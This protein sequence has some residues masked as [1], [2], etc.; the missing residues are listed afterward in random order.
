MLL[1]SRPMLLQT[2]ILSQTFEYFSI[3]TTFPTDEHE[4]GVNAPNEE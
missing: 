3:M 2:E 1:I 4:I